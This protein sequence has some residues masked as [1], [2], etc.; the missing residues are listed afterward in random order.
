MKKITYR[1]LAGFL[2]AAILM[3]NNYMDSR[4][5]LDKKAATIDAIAFTTPPLLTSA[6]ILT[7]VGY[8]LYFTSSITAIADIGHLIGRG[9]ICSLI[10]VLTLLPAL[11]YVFDKP[12]QKHMQRMQRL[13]E[14]AQERHLN[15]KNRILGK[16]NSKLAKFKAS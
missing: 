10:L 5:H 8:I 9:T 3:T 1:V 16:I 12:I 7:A 11:L 13:Q 6:T 14:K 15:R 4:S 2:A